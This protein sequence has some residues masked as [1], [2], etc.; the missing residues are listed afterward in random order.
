MDKNTV[1]VYGEMLRTI[2]G[3]GPANLSF[4]NEQFQ[5]LS[6]WKSEAREKT[7]QLMAMAERRRE[8]IVNMDN[9]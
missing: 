8:A 7:L 1:G 5:N 2:L 6:D 4:R 9:V 3:D